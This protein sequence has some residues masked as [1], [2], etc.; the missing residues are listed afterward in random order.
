MNQLEVP[1][2]TRP[3]LF[4]ILQAV[5]YEDVKDLDLGIAVRN[6]A[7]AY[8]EG[9][10]EGDGGGAWWLTGNYKTYPL[11]IN[12]QN[13]PE[14]AAFNPKVKTIPI[15]EGG[16]SFNINN[17]IANYPAIDGDTGKPAENVR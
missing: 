14:G 16:N 5:N 6:K 13:Q 17:V 11:K 3:H 7:D 8:G 1:Y 12:V 10:G 15:S 4:A 9:G 2:V